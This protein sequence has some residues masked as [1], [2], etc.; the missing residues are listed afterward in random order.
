MEVHRWGNL[1][2]ANAGLSARRCDAMLTYMLTYRAAL[3][4]HVQ[5]HPP[6]QARGSLTAPRPSS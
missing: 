6:Q 4:E 3:P 1:V 5:W 2:L